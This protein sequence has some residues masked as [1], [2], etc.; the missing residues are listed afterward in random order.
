MPS[1]Q[2]K[3]GCFEDRE[4]HLLTDF[5]CR[6]PNIPFFYLV[7][8][9]W[10]NWKAIAGGKHVQWL[11]ENKLLVSKPSES[12]DKLYTNSPKKEPEGF[13]TPLFSH[14]EIR[15]F[16]ET[17]D[18]PDLETELDRAV[19]QIETAQQKERDAKKANEPKT[20]EKSDEK[21]D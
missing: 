18:M 4:R 2:C 15:G 14:D 9:A 6:I 10:S 20:E 11:I 12:L 17:L 16:S 19:W 3:F 1:S 8:R 21:K 7:Y 5:G 13:E